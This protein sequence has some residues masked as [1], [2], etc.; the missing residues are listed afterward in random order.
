[1]EEY[2]HINGIIN[3]DKAVN[4]ITKAKKYKLLDKNYSTKIGEID[5]ICQTKDKTIVFVEVK[6]RNTERFGLGREAINEYKINKIKKT[7]MQY[8]IQTHNLDKK[9]RFDVIDILGD[10]LDYIENAF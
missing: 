5:I 3:E 10:K 7:A 4:Y 8:L 9:T 2:N 6:H 1:V